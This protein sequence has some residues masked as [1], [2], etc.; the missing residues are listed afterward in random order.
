MHTY[1]HGGSAGRGREG[2][3][4]VRARD[5]AHS[6]DLAERQA[7][8]GVALHDPERLGGQRHLR[9]S[10]RIDAGLADRAE[11]RLIVRPTENTK[12]PDIVEA[13]QLTLSIVVEGLFMRYE[14]ALPCGVREPRII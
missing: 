6:R 7:F 9:S 3:R 2:M 4:Q 8:V 5:A 12:G 1:V 13:L 10:L 11:G 14:R